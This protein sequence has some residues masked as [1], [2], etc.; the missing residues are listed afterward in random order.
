MYATQRRYD[1]IDQSRIDELTT[2][3]NDGLIP[4]L[5]TLPGFQGYY[6]TEAGNGV[7]K[8]ISFFDT[9]AHAEDSTRVAAEWTQEQN[10]QD[11]VPNAPKVSVMKVIAHEAKAPLLV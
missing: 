4:K 8:S 5:S 11:L 7:I 2:K 3:V 1:G 10:L 6:L 9:S